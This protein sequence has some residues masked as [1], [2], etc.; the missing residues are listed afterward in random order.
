MK[1]K[2][3]FKLI[4]RLVICL[5]L[6]ASVFFWYDEY[7][8][9]NKASLSETKPVEKSV[10]AKDHHKGHI[11]LVAILPLSG[12][13]SCEGTAAKQG[14]DLAIKQ[15]GSN[16]HDIEL[17]YIDWTKNS[18]EKI[19]LSQILPKNQTII[20][21]HMPTK[22]ILALAMKHPKILIIAPACSNETLKNLPNVISML[23]TDSLEGQ[24]IGKLFR[25]KFSQ[26]IKA[27]IVDGSEY[28]N[29]LYNS[30]KK[31]VQTGGTKLF[32]VKWKTDGN[33]SDKALQ[34]VLA[35][36]P[37][38]IWLAG[39]P[40]WILR[41][42]RQLKTRGYKGQFL[43]TKQFDYFFVSNIP[44]K[45]LRNFLFVRPYVTNSK[46]PRSKDFSS[47]FEKIYFTYPRW[48]SAIFYDATFLVLEK[49]VKHSRLPDKMT[50]S[51]VTGIM[52]FKNTLNTERTFYLAKFDGGTFKLVLS[53]VK[54]NSSLNSS[55]SLK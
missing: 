21:V 46:S 43:V 27:I 23:G 30:F 54:K 7:K 32:T 3:K 14:I 39:E 41:I 34:D 29:V 35:K 31:T 33:P 55:G 37:E 40:L 53:D 6:L 26:K 24:F 49:I 20:I 52:H 8:D 13:F 42:Y 15:F 5:C 25:D 38:V 51:G 36:K 48:I 28:S 4:T 18:P 1:D 11:K 17:S 2:D 16:S 47:E 45:D 22:K 19:D 10:I 9:K 12:P 44:P 50:F